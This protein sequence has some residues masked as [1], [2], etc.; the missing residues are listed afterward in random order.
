[1]FKTN[2]AANTL[3]KEKEIRREKGGRKEIK[4]SFYGKKWS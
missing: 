4:L 1:M 3:R 2:D